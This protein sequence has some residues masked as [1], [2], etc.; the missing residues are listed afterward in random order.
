MM[1]FWQLVFLS[2]PYP[3]D[4][5]DRINRFLQRTAYSSSNSNKVNCSE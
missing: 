1:N 3:D 4:S 2:L 5:M